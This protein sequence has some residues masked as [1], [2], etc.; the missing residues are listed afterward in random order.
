MA[1]SHRCSIEI[2][3]LPL[4]YPP[5]AAPASPPAATPY[6]VERPT[7]TAGAPNASA[8]AG[9]AAADAAVHEYRGALADGVDDFGQHFN[10]RDDAIEVASVVIRYVDAV[11]AVI[12]CGGCILRI[13]DAFD[14]ELVVMWDRTQYLL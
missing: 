1:N 10:R 4:Y 11:G 3:I 2:R 5:R 8:F 13:E 7:I 12:D 9:T 14:D 6:S